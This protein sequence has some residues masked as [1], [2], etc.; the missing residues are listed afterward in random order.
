MRFIVRA[1]SRGRIRVHADIARMNLSEADTLEYYLRAI[2]G[3]V[4]VK[5]YDR[6]ADAVINYTCRREDIAEALAAFSFDDDRAKALVPE[7]TSRASDRS[8]KQPKRR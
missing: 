2:P 8:A 5:V 3:V 1:E 6:T 4:H 7:H